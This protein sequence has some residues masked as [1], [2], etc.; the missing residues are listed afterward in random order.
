MQNRNPGDD[1]RR[2]LDL[3]DIARI[4]G[5]SERFARRLIQERRLPTVKVGRY[6]RVRSSDLD[7]YLDRNT[8]PAN[9]SDG[10]R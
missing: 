4:T 9:E 8:R 6:V 7:A 3:A 10:T 5:T 1:P 2:L